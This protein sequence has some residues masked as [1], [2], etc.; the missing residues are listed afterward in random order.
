MTTTATTTT[1]AATDAPVL[2]WF[3]RD[4]RLGDHRAMSAAAAS[5]RPVIPVALRDEV[6]DG[7]G[8]A[9][10]WRWGE[11]VAALTRALEGRGSAL[12]LRSGDAARALVDLVV[13]SGATEVMWLRAYEPDARARDDAVTA[14][15]AA[16]GVGVRVFA[17]DTLVERDAIATR[18]GGPYRVFTPFWHALR[19]RDIARPLPAPARWRSPT[20]WPTSERLGAWRL[21]AAMARGVA[22]V[23][24][25]VDAGE[26]AAAAKL[27]AF[28]DDAIAHYAVGRDNLA[29]AATS[30]LSDHLSVGE[31]SPRT[32]WWRGLAALEAGHDQ[33]EAFLRQLAWRD[34]AKHLMVHDPHLLDRAWREDWQR[35]PWRGDNDDAERWRRGRTGVRLVDGAMR[36]LVVTGK[37]HNRGRMIAASF[38]TKH[39]LTDWRVGAAHFEQH[40]VD[41]DAANNAMGWQWCAG[42]GPDAAPFFRVFNPDTQLARHDAQ[43]A[44]VQRWIAELAGTPSA[45]A[46]AF[47]DAIPRRWQMRPSD[48]YPTPIVELAV[49]RARALDAYR[50]R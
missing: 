36:E 22:V 44:Y 5:G 28:V 46:L 37:I 14:A 7:L 11:G 31:I 39:L 12:A 27:D 49:G 8:A 48:P 45:S 35:F 21:G 18:V 29:D 4:L 1:T 9:P 43:L 32:V 30:G 15:L 40:L 23:A 34:F 6:V 2:V 3:R 41:W 50:Q 20:R 25:H 19:T 33:A 10:K 13:E 16:R 26:D 47:F 17:G 38:L 42:S 24:D